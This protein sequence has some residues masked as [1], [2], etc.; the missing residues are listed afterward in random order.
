MP[1]KKS[2][3][4]KATASSKK[5]STAAGARSKKS[6]TP[7]WPMSAGT[8]LLAAICVTGAVIVIAAH[9]LTPAP[10]AASIDTDSEPVAASDAAKTTPSSPATVTESAMAKAPESDTPE[11]KGTVGRTAP[12]TVFGCLERS[13][14]TFRLTDTDGVDAPKARSWKTAFL[15]KGSASIEVVDPGNGLR[16]AS[17]VGQ[18][19]SVTGTLA[20]RQMRVR[21]LRRI[22]ASCS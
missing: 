9:E 4:S 18:R 1:L 19:L 13:E 6:K 16:L 10:R 17:H 14:S 20:D 22:S 5:S 21:S 3:R 12:I 7:S 15:K 2:A 11:V 8:M